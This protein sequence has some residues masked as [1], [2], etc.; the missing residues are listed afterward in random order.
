LLLLLL[1]TADIQCIG[2]DRAERNNL[3]AGMQVAGDASSG[4]GRRNCVERAAFNDDSRRVLSAARVGRS[5]QLPRSVDQPRR[6][7]TNADVSLHASQVCR[8]AQ[9]FLSLAYTCR[10]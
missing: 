2:H 7:R 10:F 9:V 6:R 1:S 5:T 8:L 4:A 3:P